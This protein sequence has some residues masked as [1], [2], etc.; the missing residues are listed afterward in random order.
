MWILLHIRNMKCAM[1]SLI[2]LFVLIVVIISLILQSIYLKNKTNR[3]D[4][5]SAALFKHCLIRFEAII[6]VKST[7]CEQLFNF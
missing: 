2:E 7:T 4:S 3:L 1:S 5:Y 6:L